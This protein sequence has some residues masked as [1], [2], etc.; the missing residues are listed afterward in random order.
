MLSNNI[1]GQQACEELDY[2]YLQVQRKNI[3]DGAVMQVA[4]AARTSCKHTY[5]SNLEAATQV[6]FADSQSY[7]GCI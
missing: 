3:Q 7:F 2:E 6:A 1:F 5:L 4:I